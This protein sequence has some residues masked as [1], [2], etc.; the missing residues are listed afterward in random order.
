M[1]IEPKIVLSLPA[2]MPG[3]YVTSMVFMKDQGLLAS[4]SRWS[5][6]TLSDLE[7]GQVVKYLQGRSESW[8]IDASSDGRLLGIAS[9]AGM[10]IWDLSS[11][12]TPYELGSRLLSVSALSFYPEMHIVAHGTHKSGSFVEVRELD[13]RKMIAQIGHTHPVRLV[14]FSPDGSVLATYS[15]SELLFWRVWEPNRLDSVFSFA[16]HPKLI[17][18]SHDWRFVATAES[19]SINVWQIET[20]VSGSYT[21][22][23]LRK[24]KEIPLTIHAPFSSMAFSPDGTTLAVGDD[25]LWLLDLVDDS[26]AELPNT[27]FTVGQIVFGHS[28]NTLGVCGGTRGPYQENMVKLYALLR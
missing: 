5:Q 21:D 26:L 18:L 27:D 15:N 8:K 28:G 25:P 1:R 16:S 23:Q 22:F 19:N 6:V 24:L 3:D 11:E 2:K 4:V 17:V 14:S 10:Q 12:A 9:D 7:A 13:D 20:G